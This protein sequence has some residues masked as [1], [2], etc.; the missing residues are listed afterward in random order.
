MIHLFH[1]T[2]EYMTLYI[3]Y[4]TSEKLLH[5][6]QRLMDM[7]PVQFP[8]LIRTREDLQYAETLYGTYGKFLEFDKKLVTIKSLL[9]AINTRIVKLHALLFVCSFRDQLW[10][11][12]NLES[13]VIEV[14]MYT[15]HVHAH[16]C[17]F[18]MA[19]I[20]ML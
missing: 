17:T 10:A 12:V 1:P 14:S 13:T 5:D 20:M 11:E 16:L 2:D 18:A 3:E 19:Y 4:A 6:V 8:E 9:Y 15:T 7:Q